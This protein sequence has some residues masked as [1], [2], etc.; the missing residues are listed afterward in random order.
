MFSI[1]GVYCHYFYMLCTFNSKQL[2]A[3]NEGLFG[4]YGEEVKNQIENIPEEKVQVLCKTKELLLFRCDHCPT[5]FHSMAAK[6]AHEKKHS[7]PGVWAQ[8]TKHSCLR[9]YQVAN[10]RCRACGKK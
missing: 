7:L 9:L 2:G 1:A 4:F 5:Q 8:C 3:D 6:V 10:G